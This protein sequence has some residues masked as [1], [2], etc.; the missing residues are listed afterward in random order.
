MTLTPNPREA[1]TLRRIR[2]EVGSIL[3]RSLFAF[4]ALALLL[5]TLLWGPWVTLLLTLTWW[6]VVARIA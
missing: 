6:R 3:G 5:G 1:S 2:R 4:S